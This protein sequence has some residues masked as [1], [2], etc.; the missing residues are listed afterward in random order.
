MCDLAE[1]YHIINYRD[2][3]QRFIST[4][5]EGLREGSRVKRHLS[6]AQVSLDVYLQAGILDR[7]TFLAWAKTKDGAKN[8]NRP[9][10][11]ASLLV[12]RQCT[13]RPR[14]SKEY[15]KLRQEIIENIQ[16]SEVIE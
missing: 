6:K 12:D 14:T 2:H 4:L 15:E 16:R 8:R 3:S 13:Q 9:K 7:L 1:Y 10:S 11:I 5:V